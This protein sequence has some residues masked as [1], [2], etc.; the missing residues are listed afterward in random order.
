MGEKRRLNL[1][2]EFFN[3]SNQ[4]KVTALDRFFATG[5]RAPGQL[6]PLA[7]R[8]VQLSIGFSSGFGKF[9]RAALPCSPLDFKLAAVWSV[10]AAVAPDHGAHGE[11][12]TCQTAVRL[13]LRK[14]GSAIVRAVARPALR[15]AAGFGN[16]LMPGD[17]G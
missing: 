10:V 2:A 16:A 4:T 14:D 7:G 13:R 6:M 12:M 9:E 8:L 3:L 5:T 11:R 15:G 17:P 1:I